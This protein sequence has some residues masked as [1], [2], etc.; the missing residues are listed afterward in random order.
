MA[1]SGPTNAHTTKVT[2]AIITTAGTNQA[3]T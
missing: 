3:A 2:T 1:G